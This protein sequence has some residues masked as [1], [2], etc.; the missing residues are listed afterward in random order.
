MFR[1]LGF[2]RRGSRFYEA[3]KARLLLALLC[4]S[5]SSNTTIIEGRPD[6]GASVTGDDASSGD[7]EGG[8]APSD[9]GPMRTDAADGGVGCSAPNGGTTPVGGDCW[10]NSDCCSGKCVTGLGLHGQCDDV[11]SRYGGTC[12]G[13]GAVTSDMGI[14]CSNYALDQV[15]NGDPD[16][17]G[18]HCR[19]TPYTCRF[20]SDCCSNTCFTNHNPPYCVRN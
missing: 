20:N 14:C 17:A 3:A 1:A 15:C 4:A 7:D 18:A 16:A 13:G 2:L 11:S 5:C 9:A 10:F 6:A 12:A 19:G 8:A